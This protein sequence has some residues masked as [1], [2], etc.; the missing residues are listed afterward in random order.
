M[1]GF[2]KKKWPALL[3]LPLSLL[4]GLTVKLRHFLYDSGLRRRFRPPVPVISV[5]N[6]TV[7]GTGKTPLVILLAGILRER[8]YAPAV[9]SRGYGRRSRGTV[10]VSDGQ[11]VLADSAAGGDEPVLMA[12]RLRGVPVVVGSDRA[13]AARYAAAAFSPDLLILDD[14]FQHRA[15][16]RDCDVIA[17][18]ALNPAG[19]G[20]MLPAGPLRDSFSRLKKADQVILTRTEQAKDTGRICGRIETITGTPPLRAAHRPGRFVPCSGDPA[21]SALPAGH[22]VYCFAGIGN[23]DSFL[24]TV[25]RTGMR[26]A[27]HTSF[28]DHHWYSAADLAKLAGRAE[29]AGGATLVTTEKDAMRLETLQPLPAPVYYLEITMEL[30]GTGTD[31]LLPHFTGRRE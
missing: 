27:G 17:I 1:I 5:G 6:I 16:D 4:F 25:E 22:A 18:D 11:S 8:G 31:H 19:N 30:S 13:A 14:A 21:G 7:G 15:I 28:P 26:V 3:L 24:D 20:F 23:P 2:W 29:A 9:I 12:R 10:V